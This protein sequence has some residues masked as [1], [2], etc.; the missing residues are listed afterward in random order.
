V[1]NRQHTQFK[2]RG[3]FGAKDPNRQDTQFKTP[4]F[5]LGCLDVENWRAKRALVLNWESWR[6]GTAA[7]G[8]LVL[9]WDSWRFGTWSPN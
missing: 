2:T 1:H 3:A 5:E 7:E 8:G 6:F 9:N 4:G